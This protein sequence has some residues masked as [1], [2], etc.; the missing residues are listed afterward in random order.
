MHSMGA[1]TYQVQWLAKH[2]GPTRN[3]FCKTNETRMKAFMCIWLYRGL[4]NDFKEPVQELW[5]S[6]DHSHPMYKVIFALNPLKFLKHCLIFHDDNSRTKDYLND[7]FAR[8]QWLVA[9]F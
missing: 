8:A 4:Y 6:V 2:K 5:S 7:R 1:K 9:S 3:W